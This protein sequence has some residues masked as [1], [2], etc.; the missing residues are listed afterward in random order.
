MTFSSEGSNV[1]QFA[2]SFG[3]VR[4]LRWSY[5]AFNLLR[6]WINSYIWCNW[7]WRTICDILLYLYFMCDELIT[8]IF[9]WIAFDASYTPIKWWDKSMGEK[10]RNN[11]RNEL[12]GINNLPSRLIPTAIHFFNRQYWQRFLLMRRMLHC[13]FFVHGRYWIFCCMD[14]R[15]NPYFH[16]KRNKIQNKINDILSLLCEYWFKTK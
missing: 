8:D 7:L 12:F 11:N 14:R 16:P 3:V 2:R 13:W 1:E 5:A 9:N 15:K 6:Y 10:I 4:Y